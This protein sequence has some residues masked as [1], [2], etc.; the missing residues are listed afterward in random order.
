MQ[1]C[2]QHPL[3]H[4]LH[5]QRMK[6]LLKVGNTQSLRYIP[7]LIPPRILK[8]DYTAEQRIAGS[9]P[10]IGGDPVERAADTPARPRPRR[11]GAD[12][13]RAH[14]DSVCALLDDD[15]C[16]VDDPP[17]AS[18]TPRDVAAAGPAADDQVVDDR[19]VGEG[20]GV[21]GARPR[22]KREAEVGVVLVDH[23][24]ID[25]GVRRD[26]R[27]ARDDAVPERGHVAPRDLQGGVR[28]VGRLAVVY[29]E[30]DTLGVVRQRKPVV[31]RAVVAHPHNGAVLIL[32]EHHLEGV[33][34][35]G[36]RTG[37]GG[38]EVRH[39]READAPHE[40][41]LELRVVVRVVARGR[42]AGRIIQREVVLLDVKLCEHAGVKSEI[43][44]IGIVQKPL[45][46][47]ALAAAV[48]NAEGI[49]RCRCIIHQDRC[50]NKH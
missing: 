42:A 14:H 7:V 12:P 40:L 5:S 21:A 27:A 23:R 24:R 17:G 15:A 46:C 10:T 13:A 3:P 48:S 11:G 38:V 25:H 43:V 29:V 6:G 41:R 16:G 47:C 39:T 22:Q 31:H 2:H 44:D 8:L 37:H 35:A 34:Q 4:H 9:A 1:H 18:S 30:E 19:G 28:Q 33:V 32:V 45:W 20:D 26:R 36:N 50:K 49:S